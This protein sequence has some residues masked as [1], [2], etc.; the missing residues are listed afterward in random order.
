MCTILS[1]LPMD[2]RRRSNTKI[3]SLWLYSI[4]LKLYMSNKYNIS[5]DWDI[6][7]GYVMNSFCYREAPCHS[8]YGP[9]GRRLI[10]ATATPC[11]SF[12]HLA[13]TWVG[14]WKLLGGA[15]HEESYAAPSYEIWAYIHSLCTYIRIPYPTSTFKELSTPI[16][17][18]IEQEVRSNPRTLRVLTNNEQ[19]ILVDDREQQAF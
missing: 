4:R 17:L 5:L 3:A 13:A 18:E 8:P 1:K 7:R 15:L 9:H 10:L 12:L 11:S 2:R 19:I 16:N 6:R 14:H